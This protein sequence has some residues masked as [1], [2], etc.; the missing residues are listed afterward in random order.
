MF[1]SVQ[2]YGEKKRKEALKCTDFSQHPQNR[3]IAIKHISFPCL[4]THK[5]DGTRK[6][7]SPCDCTKRLRTVF[8]YGYPFLDSFM[9]KTDFFL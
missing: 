1:V 8:K 7:L 3:Y 9:L 6:V 5:H 2:L 4:S